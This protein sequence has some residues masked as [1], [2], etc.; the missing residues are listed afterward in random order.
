MCIFLSFTSV[1]SSLCKNKLHQNFLFGTKFDVRSRQGDRK[2]Y[3]C[4]TI[5]DRCDAF[6]GFRVFCPLCL[7]LGV[8]LTLL[9]G[10]ASTKFLLILPVRRKSINIKDCRYVL[11]DFAWSYLEYDIGYDCCTIVMY[12]ITIFFVE[13]KAISFFS[14]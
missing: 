6:C 11:V 2:L 10:N 4:L 8:M 5:P 7:R 13:N 14:Y 12:I 3:F 1:E 9:F